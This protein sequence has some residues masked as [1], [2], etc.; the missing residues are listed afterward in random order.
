M[1]QHL[2]SPL[3]AVAELE[4][5]ATA[6]LT[7]DAVTSA[8]ITNG[9]T[10]GTI[11]FTDNTSYPSGDSRKIVDLEVYDYFGSKKEGYINTGGDGTAVLNL[12]GLNNSRGFALSVKVVSTNGLV[13]D[14]SQFKISNTVSIGNFVMEK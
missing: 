3:P 7:A 4:P 12:G 1:K 14:G 9:G 5:A 8:T 10:G 6:V 2:Q 13:K 11:T